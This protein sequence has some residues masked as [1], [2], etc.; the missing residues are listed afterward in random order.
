[1]EYAFGACCL[2]VLLLAV[3]L[4]VG[5]WRRVRWFLRG[6]ADREVSAVCVLCQGRGWID[7]QQRTLTFTGEGFADV[8]RPALRCEACDGTGQVRR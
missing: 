6:R 8:D 2:L 5:Q 3:G 7:Q 4:A 1:M